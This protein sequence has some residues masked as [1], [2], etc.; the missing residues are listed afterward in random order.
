M[1]I[2]GEHKVRT[3]LFPDYRE[4]RQLLAVWAGTPRTAVQQMIKSIQDQTGTPQNPVDWS[5]P[6][7]WIQE[8]LS[9]SARELALRVWNESKNTVNPRHTYGSYLF[10]NHYELLQCDSSGTYFLSDTGSKF[11]AE[12]ADVVRAIDIAEG[13]PHLLSILATCSPAR[14]GDLVG[15]WRAFLLEHS[16]FGTPTTINETLRKRMLNLVER[17]FVDREGNTYTITNKGIEYA[18]AMRDSETDE[19]GRNVRFAI[20][21]YNDAQKMALRERLG[22]MDPYHFEKL[23]SDLLEAMDHEDVVVT[24]Q[25]GDKGIDV[26]GKYQF[27]ITEIREVVQVKRQQGSVTRPILDQ[28]RGALPYHQAI[29]GTII[30]LGKFAKGCRDAA[31]F[32]GAAPITLIDGDKLMELLLKHQVGVSKRSVELFEVDESYFDTSA[33]DPDAAPDLAQI[34]EGN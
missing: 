20:K 34:P 4:V 28:L 13:L 1:R 3:P 33:D 21:S 25:S 8:R 31:I 32:Q 16:K 10:I 15:E 29:R 19:P 18:S 22:A 11:M 27:G 6:D 24:K 9:G 30:T 5:N 7:A 17:G 14:R 12:D 23:I 2:K 26:V